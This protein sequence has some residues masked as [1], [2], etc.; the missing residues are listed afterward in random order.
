MPVCSWHVFSPSTPPPPLRDLFSP[1]YFL[2]L[3]RED[4]P[5][6]FS[7]YFIIHAIRQRGRGNLFQ[8]KVGGFFGTRGIKSTL[9]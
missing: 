8:R 2:T 6:R 1:V 9:M 5:P 4:R 7:Q 3:A